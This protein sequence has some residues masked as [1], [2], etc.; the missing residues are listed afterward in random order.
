[1]LESL[2]RVL[3]PGASLVLCT[4]YDWSGAVTVP[5]AWVGGH[6][7]RAPGR[8]APE[9]VLRALLTPGAH[10]AS[11]KGLRLTGEVVHVPWHLRSHDRSVTAYDVHLVTARAEKTS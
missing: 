2:S 7:D 10:P 5:G 1:M 11:V 6:S 4:P 8:G 3:K 9:P